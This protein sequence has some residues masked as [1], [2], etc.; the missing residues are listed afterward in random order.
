MNRI[1]AG[2]FAIIG[3]GACG[4]STVALADDPAG[5]YLGA[6]VGESN[7]RNDGYGYNGYYGYNDHQSAWKLIAGIRPIPPV[8]AEFEYIDFGSANGRANYFYSGNYFNGNNSDAKATALFGVGYLPL[9][10]PFLDVFG[11]AGVARLQSNTAT[12][13]SPCQAPATCVGTVVNNDNWSTNFAY[14]VGVQTK[15]LGLAVRAEYERI[16]AAGGDPDA[17]MVSAAW[18][19]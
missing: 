1:S 16:S 7:L 12:Y 6:G 2:I 18:T 3:L 4:A 11:K 19:F 8:G 10:L 5:F 13:Y 15:W 14:G 17:L 9:G